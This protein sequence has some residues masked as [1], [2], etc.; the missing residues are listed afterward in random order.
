M[1]LN[2][3]QKIASIGGVLIT[4]TFGI[5]KGADYFVSTKADLAVAPIRTRLEDH[6]QRGA[7]ETNDLKQVKDDVAY[8]RGLLDQRYGKPAKNQG[9]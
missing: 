2:R 8:I 1:E 3:A 7:E 4:L 6:I 5:F 9:E